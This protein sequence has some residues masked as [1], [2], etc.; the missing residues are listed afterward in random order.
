VI[1]VDT[2]AMGTLLC[3]E[4]VGRTVEWAVLST[5]LDAGAR[6]AGSAMLLTGEA[7]VG[8][9]RLVR[10][11]RKRCVDRGGVALLGRAVDTATPTPFRPLSEALMAAY[12]SGIVAGAPDGAAGQSALAPLL[13]GYQAGSGSGASV[14]Q[15]AE[16][17]L[18]VVR[19]IGQRHDRGALVVLEDLHWADAE[20]LAVVEYLADN[21]VDL[22]VLLV[23]TT[24]PDIDRDAVQSVFSLVDRRAM[25]R[26]QLGRLNTAQTVEMIRRCLGEA[27]APAEVLELVADRADGLPFF[28]EELLTG[29]HSDGSLTRENGQWVS[30]RSNKAVAPVTF[31]ES[32]R[33]RMGV[34]PPRSRQLL[35]DAALLGRQI[36]LDVLAAIDGCDR[37][38]VARAMQQPVAVGLLSEDESGMRFRHALTRDVVTAGLRP[39]DRAARARHALAM[40]RTTSPAVLEADG[41]AAADLAEWAGDGGAAAELLLAVA[42][43]A[44]GQGALTSAES[45]LRRA[46]RLTVSRCGELEILECLVETMALAGRVDEVFPLGLAVLARIGA[47][48]GIDPYGRRRAAIHLALA[49]SAVAC[50]DWSLA[51]HHLDSARA[52]VGEDDPSLVARVTAVQ[53]VVAAGEYRPG[54]SGMLAAA[55]VAAAESSADPDLLCEALLVRGRC[56]RDTDLAVAERAF[57]RARDVARDAGLAHRQARALAELGTIDFHRGGGPER[58]REARALARACGACETEAVAEQHLAVLAWSHGDVDVMLEHAQAAI[59]IARRFRL[60]MLLPSALIL[61]ACAHALRGATD[62]MEHALAEATPLIEGDPTQ[63]VASHAQARAT[64]ALARDDVETA[65]VELAVATAIVRSRRT[66]PVPMVGMAVLLAAI[67]GADPTGDAHELRSMSYHQMQPL[68]ALLLA[69]DAVAL[70]RDAAPAAGATMAQAMELLG[71]QPFM[72]AVCLRLVAPRAA[73]DG[74]GDPA[75][76]LRTA[77][78]IFEERGLA[79]PARSVAVMRR[80]LSGGRTVAPGSGDRRGSGDITLREREVLGLVAEG[81]PNRSIAARLYLSPRTVEKH[82]QR[83]MAKTGTANRAQLATYALK[84]S[85]RS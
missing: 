20:T 58:L 50:T 10:E 60:G 7:G 62:A 23:A 80:Q 72:L 4:V 81:L 28:V 78:E 31:A 74:W 27:T 42:R 17:F 16:G 70:G 3:P 44:L 76:W 69:A 82:V 49:R 6:G 84:Q 8:K 65:R 40:L 59:G 39:D 12:R 61:Q 33:R 75:E 48:A 18:R 2:C 51:S 5:A 21:V 53:A 15:V 54:D 43:R 37:A 9:S 67:D 38:A 56:A 24:R 79:E 29:L 47:T 77:Q 36:D 32:V 26:L 19:A 63:T 45:A 71:T 83:L 52:Y 13:P 34:L 68:S 14:L 46:S 64:C 57:E 25:T 1:C 11:L 85:S 30:S 73:A 22:P 55:A 41:V 35:I 66:A